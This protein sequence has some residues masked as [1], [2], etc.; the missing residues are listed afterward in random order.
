[1]EIFVKIKWF[2]RFLGV[3]IIDRPNGKAVSVVLNIMCLSPV[4]F[5]IIASM[6]FILFEAKTFSEQAEA[7]YPLCAMSYTF[8]ACFILIFRRC[9]IL[10]LFNQL[11][12]KIEERKEIK[13]FCQH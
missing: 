4:M 5:L 8:V 6:L 10:Q 12:S 2:L 7:I 9:Q 1:M 13:M 3:L 11:D